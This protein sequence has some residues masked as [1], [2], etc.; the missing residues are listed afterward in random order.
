MDTYHE[1]KNCKR[2][3]S[4]NYPTPV[5]GRPAEGGRRTV[6]CSSTPPTF[7]LTRSLAALSQAPPGEEVGFPRP[8][9]SGTLRRTS[10]LRALS[11]GVPLVQAC[12]RRAQ[13]LRG[14]TGRVPACDCPP[15]PLPSRQV[16]YRSKCTMLLPPWHSLVPVGRFRR[17]LWLPPPPRSLTANIVPT[18]TVYGHPTL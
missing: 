5:R 8:T 18:V 6:W 7:P 17:G 13:S 14:G 1:L 16:P 9:R 2:Q 12:S 4:S 3:L 10:G 15:T 11:R